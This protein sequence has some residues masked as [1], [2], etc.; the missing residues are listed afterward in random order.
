MFNVIVAGDEVV[1]KKPAPDVY[2]EVLKMLDL[3]GAECVAIEDSRNGLVSAMAAG[4]PVLITHSL[5]SRRDNFTGAL[6]VLEDLDAGS[7]ADANLKPGT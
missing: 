5:Y 2:L 6:A 1:A 3:A 7:A 4:I